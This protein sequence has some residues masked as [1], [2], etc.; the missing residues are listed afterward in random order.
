VEVKG[1][2]KVANAF[3]GVKAAIHQNH[4]LLTASR[5]SIEA[6]AF[7]FIALE[8]CCKQQMAVEATGIKPRLVSPSDHVTA[9][10]TWA[11]NTLVG[12]I[13]SP[14]GNT[15]WQPSPTCSSDSRDRKRPDMKKEEQMDKAKS[16]SAA[17]AAPVKKLIPYGGYYAKQ[18]LA[19]DPELTDDGAWHASGRVFPV[20][21]GIRS[22]CRWS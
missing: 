18:T 17:A 2:H 14:S 15:C 11:A 10:N 1:G 21:F 8:R 20:A 13:S 6:A 16:A 5:H 7:W 12:C 22:A 19:H 3:K 9:V 4:G